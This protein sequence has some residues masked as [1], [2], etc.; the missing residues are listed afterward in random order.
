MRQRVDLSDSLLWTT[1][2]C[3][4]RR[5]L[6]SP[7]PPRKVL[8]LGSP[9]PRVAP[10]LPVDDIHN[11]GRPELPPS[12]VDPDAGTGCRRFALDRSLL[13][14]SADELEFF[15]TQTDIES[16]QALLDHV[17]QVASETYQVRSLLSRACLLHCSRVTTRPRPSSSPIRASGGT[18]S[19]SRRCR[20]VGP[21]Y[22]C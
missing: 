19:L 21:L 4:L 11:M 7:P 10:S 13:R 5:W 16:E 12:A 3:E 14:L 20:R 1:A 6:C 22:A 9:C 8:K 18:H 2:R 15:K 17:H